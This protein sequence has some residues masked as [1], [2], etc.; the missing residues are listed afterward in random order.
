MI[1]AETS[2]DAPRRTRGLIIGVTAALLGLGGA[3]A[4]AALSYSHTLPDLAK[5]APGVTIGAVPVGGLTR[6]EALEKSRNWARERLTDA[7][8]LTAPVTGKKWAITTGELGGRGHG[9]WL[10]NLGRG[11]NHAVL[12]ADRT[13]P[14]LQ[15]QRTGPAREGLG[16]EL[17]PLDR[18][19]P[20]TERHDRA[21]GCPRADLELGR[22]RALVDHQ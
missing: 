9:G 16:V 10:E 22:E 15:Q 14:V 4:G 6:E 13:Q 1:S 2:T 19:T 8:V 3:G 11:D 20:V 12:G 17:N 5:I 18:Q 21:I 7:I